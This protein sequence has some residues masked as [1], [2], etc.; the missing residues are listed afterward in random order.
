VILDAM[1]KNATG[2]IQKRE[3]KEILARRAPPPGG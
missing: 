1:P 2:K 3:V